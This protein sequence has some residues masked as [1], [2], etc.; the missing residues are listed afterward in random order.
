MNKPGPTTPTPIGAVALAELLH[1]AEQAAERDEHAHGIELALQ[2]EA[3]SRQSNDADSLTKALRL[4]VTLNGREGLA[5][6]AI[7]AGQAV[8][9]RLR[10]TSTLSTRLPSRSTTSKRQPCH[11]T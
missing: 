4:L 8:L 5:E 7:A 3:L 6:Q 9:P 2:A 10:E 1:R 11:S